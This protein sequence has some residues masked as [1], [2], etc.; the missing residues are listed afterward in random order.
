ME[1]HIAGPLGNAADSSEAFA[2]IDTT[3]LYAALAV[4]IV[5]LLIT[6][7]SPILWLLPVISAGLA[8][9]TSQAVI[10][11]LAAH[12]GLTVNAQSAGIL[13]VLVFGAGTDYALLLVARYREEL[14]RHR[15]RHEAMAIALQRAGPAVVASAGTVIL[16]LLTLTVAEL[17]STKGMGPVLAIGVAVALLAMLTL[18][19]AMLV[20]TGRWVFWPIRPR[21]GSEE[22]TTRGFWA[23]TGR[24]IAV[25]PRVTWITHQP[26][27][28]RSG[29]RR[30]R[31]ARQRPDKRGVLPRPPGLGRRRPGAGAPLPGGRRPARR[32]GRQ[33]IVGRRAGLGSAHGSRHH[34]GD[35]AEGRRGPRLPGGHPHRAAGQPGRLRND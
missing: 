14:R 7:R 19:P 18:L 10:Y 11:L 8:L 29:A 2:G 12:A 23:R 6:Y 24:A 3:L 16:G 35:R 27:A 32:R 21:F 15:D 13:N 26:G 31:P 22:P 33:R 30:D 9:V 28:R 4:V 5:L 25:R 1:V 20:A 34:G 17:N